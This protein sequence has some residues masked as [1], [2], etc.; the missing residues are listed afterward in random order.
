MVLTILTR[1]TLADSIQAGKSSSALVLEKSNKMEESNLLLPKLILFDAAGTLFEV[2][3]SVGEVYR[4]YAHRFGVEVEASALQ[5]RFFAAFQSQ[6]PLAFQGFGSLATLHRLE[7]EWWQQLVRQVFIGCNFPHFDDFFDSLFE[8]FRAPEAWQLFAD[9]VPALQ[10][11]QARGIT[12]AVLS[13]FD[14]RLLNVL[15]GLALT[16]YFAGVHYSS[17]L[18]AAKPDSLV[19]HRVVQSY[20]LWPA[21]A[22][23][24]GDSRREDYEGATH[25]GLKAWWLDRAGSASASRLSRLDQLVAL[26]A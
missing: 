6:P 5:A 14:S 24:V 21:E 17:E 10:A 8:H 15:A 23:H 16:P 20:G 22:W 3:G 2:R 12:L 4:T 7:Y 11:L 19:F 25:A 26:V 1:V 13:N 18:G 9:V